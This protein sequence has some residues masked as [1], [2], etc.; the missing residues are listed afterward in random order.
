MKLYEKILLE[1]LM[2]RAS[3]LIYKYILNQH[4]DTAVCEFRMIIFQIFC[5]IR[6]NSGLSSYS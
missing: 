5:I 3:A 2:N 4:I 6:G 1:P